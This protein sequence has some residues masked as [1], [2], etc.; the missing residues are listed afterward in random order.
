[1]RLPGLT[2]LSKFNQI[3]ASATALA[4]ALSLPAVAGQKSDPT[5]VSMSITGTC[6]VT[7]ADVDFGSLEQVLG[8]EVINSSVSV[9][10]SKGLPFRL[11]FSPTANTG[12][13][14]ANLIPVGPGNPDRIPFR[15]TRVG[16]ATGIGKGTTASDV[17][18]VA[19]R[20]NLTAARTPR[21]GTYVRARTIYINY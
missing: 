15:V 21:P 9:L 11:T 13:T 20:T 19:L 12:S 5:E 4:I 17:I 18:S 7:V 8:T 6:T 14:A 10:C 1:L 16:P 2:T 3:A